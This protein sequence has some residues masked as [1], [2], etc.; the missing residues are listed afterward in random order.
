MLIVHSA[1]NDG[2]DIDATEHY[3][4][5]VARQGAKPHRFANWIEV[6][7]STRSAGP[8]LVAG[9][10]NYGRDSVDLFAPGSEIRSTVPGDGYEEAEGTSM[11]APQVA[12]V[13]A[14]V[15]SQYPRLTA[16]DLRAVLLI[17]ARTY[18]EL[19]VHRPGGS[20]PTTLS[21][22]CLSGGIVDAF[23]ALSYLAEHK[24]TLVAADRVKVQELTARALTPR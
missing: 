19:T 3:P 16:A 8:G 4:S 9:F 6:G 22:L 12:G 24:G 2:A 17:T 18:P 10:S 11:A 21:E 5:P 20:E 1:G 23:A 13:A 15:W 14:L 7:A